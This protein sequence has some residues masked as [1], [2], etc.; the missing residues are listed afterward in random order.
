MVVHV[1]QAPILAENATRDPLWDL[2]V[3]CVIGHYHARSGTH[4]PKVEAHLLWDDDALYCRWQVSDLREEMVGRYTQPNDP[5]YTDS[6]VEIFIGSKISSSAYMNIEV[7]CLGAILLQTNLEPRGGPGS[8]AAQWNHRIERWTSLMG[9][10]DSVLARSPPGAFAWSASVRIPFALNDELLEQRV[11]AAEGGRAIPAMHGRANT[12]PAGLFKCADDAP[13]PH[14][15]SWADI[16]DELNFHQPSKFG[17]LV[18]ARARHP[19]AAKKRAR[20]S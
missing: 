20:A 16:G 14:W 2:A 12:L 8:D 15:G 1:D 19:R 9:S 4:Q 10:P 17:T 3:P 18:F 13:R 6:C 7:N 5:V 11:A